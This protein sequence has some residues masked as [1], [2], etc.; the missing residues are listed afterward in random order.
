[1]VLRDNVSS[2]A[3]FSPR[4]ESI[5]AVRA[6]MPWLV[7]FGQDWADHVEKDTSYQYKITQVYLFYRLL[8]VPPDSQKL[9]LA[10][11]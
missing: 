4:G 6:A 5:W 7:S 2:L 11:R 10:F 3:V 8:Q 9:A 1:M